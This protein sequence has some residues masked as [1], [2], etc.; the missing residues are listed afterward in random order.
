MGF[1]A[2]AAKEPR[3]PATA[4]SEICCKL[5]ERR[6]DANEVRDEE[7]EE[8]GGSDRSRASC[9]LVGARLWRDDLAGGGGGAND[10]SGASDMRRRGTSDDGASEVRRPAVDA[11]VGAGRREVRLDA[12][13]GCLVIVDKSAKLWLDG[14]KR[15]ALRT[16]LDPPDEKEARERSLGAIKLADRTSPPPPPTRPGV[17]VVVVA[18]ALR[19]VSRSLRSERSRSN[20]AA[21]DSLRSPGVAGGGGAEVDEVGN[22]DRRGRASRPVVAVAEGP[23]EGRTNDRRAAAGVARVDAIVAAAAGVVVLARVRVDACAVGAAAA[24]AE[25]DEETVCRCCCFCARNSSRRRLR[26]SAPDIAFAFAAGVGVGV[27]VLDCT[28]TGPRGGFV[29]VSVSV[30]V[31]ASADAERARASS[32]LS[33][34]P[35]ATASTTTVL[36]ILDDRLGAVTVRVELANSEVTGETGGET[37]ASRGG[38][39]NANASSPPRPRPSSRRRVPVDSGLSAPVGGLW[40][41]L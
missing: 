2:T 24:A 29:V 38:D 33:R 18:P 30:S 34:S 36:A 25:E 4:G 5:D 15:P 27:A 19:I 32:I 9:R 23:N 16:S 20:L 11:G 21:V 17:V 28:N 31:S 13:A 41:K 14:N 8:E 1:I 35:S 39:A 12:V 26:R 37:E 6:I 10:D 3:R 40:F 7:E 22:A